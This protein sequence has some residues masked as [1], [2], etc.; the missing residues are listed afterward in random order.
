MIFKSWVIVSVDLQKDNKMW[1][2]TTCD[3]CFEIGMPT[4]FILMLRPRSGANQW[5]AREVYTLN[6]IVPALEY[7]DHYGNLCQRL[8]APPGVFSIHTN[9]DIYTSEQ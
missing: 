8:I 3:I 1:L 9:A 7:T 2:R 5:I 4:P 6:P